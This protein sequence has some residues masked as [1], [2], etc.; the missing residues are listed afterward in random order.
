MINMINIKQK[1]IIL[2]WIIIL[3]LFTIY[4]IVKLKYISFNLQE[5]Y[6]NTSIATPLPTSIFEWIDNE[7][8]NNNITTISSECSNVYD[9]NY[10]VNSI[11]YSD[12][13]TAY[14]N[15][16]A[17]GFDVNNNFGQA[18]SL[19]DMCPVTTKSDLYSSCLQKL[20]FKF[21]NS[22]N[23]V[24]N[25]TFDMSNSINTRLNDRNVAI[26]NIQDQMK[27]YLLSKNQIDFASF[28]KN[29][30]AVAKYS[31]D[32]G[33]LVNKYY[34]NRYNDGYNIGNTVVT[35][36]IFEG[37]SNSISFV[38]PGIATLFF[39]YYKPLA[40]Q[41][42]VLND[43]T[44]SLNYDTSISIPTQQ[45]QQNPALILTITNNNG[46]QISFNVSK[47]NNFNSLPNAVVMA[48]DSKQVISNPT[49][50]NT[51]RQL[52]TTLGINDMSYLIMTY[53]EFTSTENVLH[54]TY[55]L[56]NENLDTIIILNKI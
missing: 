44:I 38:D 40:G 1:Y 23:I 41:F 8:K 49:D 21:T 56:V 42:L 11:G 54:K 3:F 17:K 51:L 47:I 19:A 26:N 48:L 22:S 28:M 14:D 43:I 16:L 25:V 6:G 34:K 53:E 36:K 31:D 32:I 55:K 29:N 39:G 24:D 7:D 5:K 45:T 33:G 27:P 20:L 2:I 37:F 13:Q 15:Y 9:D 35:K 4:C 46:L 52:L 30:N 50:T 12:C 18:K 10:A